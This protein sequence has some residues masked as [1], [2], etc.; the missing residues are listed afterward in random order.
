MTN[1][2]KTQWLSTTIIIYYILWFLWIMNFRKA[3]A[4]KFSFGVSH[5]ISVSCLLEIQSSGDLFF[6]NWKGRII[7]EVEPRAQ[8]AKGNH[9]QAVE[10]SLNQRTGNMYLPGLQNTLEQWLLCASHFSQF[11]IGESTMVILAWTP[12]HVGWM[13]N[14][15]IYCFS[16]K[17]FKSRTIL[18]A[19]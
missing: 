12:L 4:R 14:Q 6:F 7:Q 5:V 8:E 17:A 13:E 15:I 10:L 16:S 9:S 2:P 18:K 3:S 11:G 19:C 1:F